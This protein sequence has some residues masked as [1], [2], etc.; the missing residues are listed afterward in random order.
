MSERAAPRRAKVTC[1]VV[2]VNIGNTNLSFALF[3][4]GKMRWAR[5]LPVERA[6]RT[7]AL[8]GPLKDVADMVIASV[9]PA[10]TRRVAAAFRRATGRAPIIIG[11]EVP[12]PIIALTEE[13]RHVGV[14]RLLNALAAYRRCHGSAI[15][16]DVGTA[17]TLDLVSRRGEFMGGL[18]APGMRLAAL[19]LGEH[20]ALLPRVTMRRPQG[21]FGKNTEEA[22]RSGVYWGT[23]NMISGVTTMLQKRLGGNTS[24]FLTGGGAPLLASRLSRGF[25]HLPNLTLEGILCAYAAW[26][27][28]RSAPS[29][30][31]RVARLGGRRNGARH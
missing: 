30:R 14:D 26:S 22:I 18:I 27:R 9:N 20:T 8:I 15:V 7:V 10:C 24:L 23:I 17:I 13:P 4:G 29:P 28:F 6:D 11:K 19:A 12:V 5:W 25:V 2:A 16:V 1:R 31:L 3:E 21:L